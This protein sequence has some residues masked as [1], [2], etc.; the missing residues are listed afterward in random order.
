[1][2]LSLALVACTA[3]GPPAPDARPTPPPAISA[4]VIDPPAPWSRDIRASE[5]AASAISHSLTRPLCEALRREDAAALSDLLT[6]DFRGRF[7]GNPTPVA[8]DAQLDRLTRPVDPTTR[9]RAELVSRLLHA[10][11]AFRSLDRCSLGVFR[12]KLGEP[13]RDVAWARA[14]LEVVGQDVDGRPLQW[15][16]DL[17]VNLR[18]AL[19]AWRIHELDPGPLDA[20]VTRAPPF[21]DASAEVGFGL[22][23]ARAAAQAVQTQANNK[24][25]ETIGGLAVVDFD[26]DARPDV[27]VWNQ[28][29]LLLLFRNDGR[30]GFERRSDLIPREQIGLHHLYADLDG[31]GVEE[32]VSTEL[33]GCAGGVGR[34]PLFV[35]TG[36]GFAPGPP[37]SFALP[38]ANPGSTE[39]QHITAADVNADGRLDLIVSGF[40]DHNSR[41]GHFNHFDSQNGRRNL[42]FINQGGLRFTEEGE[43]RGLVGRRFTY[44]STAFDADGDGDVDLYFANDFGP[45]AL[46]HNDGAGRFTPVK[47]GPLVENGQS[48]GLTVA[49][50][51]GD[52]RLDVYVSNMYSKAGNR[53]VPLAR[54]RLSLKTVR[55]LEGLAAGNALFRRTADGYTRHAQAAGIDR[56][57]WAWGQAFFDADN[58]GDRDLYVVN[59]MTSHSAKAAPDF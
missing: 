30:G 18:R 49:D 36:D 46:F 54:N 22:R 23:R 8:S 27:L 1:M 42:L 44:V 47:D 17:T 33:A 9:S 35:R 57:G 41:G 11:A 29:R 14:H 37:L 15:R 34:L 19:N 52:L 56:A 32:L 39:H 58:D 50:F 7:W 31:D 10:R 28:R 6:P 48:M 25:I 43:A 20:V 24:R 4:F 59:G 38:C 12:I 16:A 21:V 5:A 55:T 26:R 3:D 45:N 2:S 40:G 13:S 51:D 53:I